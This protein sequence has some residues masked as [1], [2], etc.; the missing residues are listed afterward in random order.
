MGSHK[1]GAD[2][3]DPGT[4]LACIAGD[5]SIAYAWEG[6]SLG[7]RRYVEGCAIPGI[8]NMAPVEAK[9]DMHIDFHHTTEDVA[10]SIGE[11]VAKA[12]QSAQLEQALFNMPPGD[13]AGGERGLAA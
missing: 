4:A 8:C 1:S 12:L 9:G 13:W 10:I 5:Y 6:P 11:A 3:A 7:F 2:N